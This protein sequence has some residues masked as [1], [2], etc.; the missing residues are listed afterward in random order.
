MVLQ[1][2]ACVCRNGAH[3][4]GQQARKWPTKHWHAQ[5]KPQVLAGNC[6]C[7]VCLLPYR[8]YQLTVRSIQLDR[9]F[10]WVRACAI[11][12]WRTVMPTLAGRHSH[13]SETKQH[14]VDTRQ[15]VRYLA[16]YLRLCSLCESVTV[17]PSILSLW[18]NTNRQTLLH[19]SLMPACVTLA[20]V[21][22]EITTSVYEKSE[23][24]GQQT[25][26]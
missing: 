17:W 5:H 8:V 11:G 2:C 15:L 13:W 14:C 19:T 16:Y 22:T 24:T 3:W 10:E 9:Y 25:N 21:A 20:F 26:K 4:I 7:F 23:S 12:N 6:H 1:V 18:Y